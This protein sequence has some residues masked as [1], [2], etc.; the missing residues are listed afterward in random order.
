MFQEIAVTVGKGWSTVASRVEL[1]GLTHAIV[2]FLKYS[3]KIKAKKLLI[4]DETFLITL[5]VWINIT[6][7]GV[8]KYHFLILGS[9][10]SRG[11]DF[12]F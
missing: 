11:N 2:S 6:P 7:N 10:D 4:L 1:R 9:S 5:N 3:P 8:T 12:Q